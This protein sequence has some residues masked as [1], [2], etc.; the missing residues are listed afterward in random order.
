M[1]EY[2]DKIVCSTEGCTGHTLYEKNGEQCKECLSYFCELCC[3]DGVFDEDDLF[4]C[5]LCD[6]HIKESEKRPRQSLWSRISNNAEWAEARREMG[7]YT[8]QYTK[9][10]CERCGDR[11]WGTRFVRTVHKDQREENKKKTLHIFLLD[12]K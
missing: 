12:Q 10:R 1:H 8:A 5:K 9:E 3:D 11:L 7:F 4:T 2:A 6:E